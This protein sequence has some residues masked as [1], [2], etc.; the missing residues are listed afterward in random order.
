MKKIK[1]IM[2]VMCKMIVYVILFGIG[3]YI[4]AMSLYKI[5]RPFS[6]LWDDFYKDNDRMTYYVNSPLKDEYGEINITDKTADLQYFFDVLK[7]SCASLPYMEKQYGFSASEMRNEYFSIIEKTSSDYEYIGTLIS[8]LTTACCRT[9]RRWFRI[10][11][12]CLSGPTW[13]PDRRGFS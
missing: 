3:Y 4:Y 7:S 8:R 13:L 6:P 11:N 10:S 5:T 12:P 2:G 1:K 9:P